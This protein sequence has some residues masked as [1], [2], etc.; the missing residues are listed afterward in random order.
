[1]IRL[2]FLVLTTLTP[3]DDATTALTNARLIPV[4]GAVVEKG[5]ILVRSGKIIAIGAAVEIP[6]KAVLVDLSGRTVIPGLVL[7]ASALGVSGSANEDGE[8]VAPRMRI[9]D[10]FDPRSADLSRARQSGVTAALIEP[11][12]RGVIGG[13]GAVVKTA[14]ASKSAMILREDATL[15]GAMGL[16]PAQGNYPPRGNAATFFARR[17]TTRMGVAWEFRKAFFDGRRSEEKDAGGEALRKALSGALPVRISA[18]RVTDLETA[19]QIAGEFQLRVSVEEAQEAYKRAELL[20]RKG[21][22]V[23]LRPAPPGATGE[24]E[25]FRLDTFTVLLRAGVPTAL[26]PSDDQKPENFLASI[27]FAV[28]H[29]ATPA[30]ALRGA[31]LTPAEILG[32]ADRI[33][34]LEAGR[35]ADLVVLSGEPHEVT[36]RVEKVMIDGRWMNGDKA[37]P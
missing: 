23:L 15:K 33:G 11:G 34:S 13:L 19:L 6:D 18:S 28:R 14:G 7:G 22:P 27:A 10:S 9:S 21:I 35:D 5:T 2:A 36:T 37:G 4:S 3:Q 20:A 26:L 12:N 31:T 16:A 24:P 32:V 8:E 1:M 29:G 30:E 25:D 17:P